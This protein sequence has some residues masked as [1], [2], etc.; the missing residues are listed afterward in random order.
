MSKIKREE[1]M[2]APS[3]RRDSERLAKALAIKMAYANTPDAW[4]YHDR[5]MKIFRD[6]QE[7]YPSYDWLSSEFMK[8]MEHAASQYKIIPGKDC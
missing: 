3:Q 4:K 6:L 1:Q 2:K 5:W 8:K 7:K